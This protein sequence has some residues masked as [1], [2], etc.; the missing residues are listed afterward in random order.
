LPNIVESRNEVSQTNALPLPSG[1]MV[2]TSDDLL[3]VSSRGGAE[4]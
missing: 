4:G 2:V 3:G 1:R